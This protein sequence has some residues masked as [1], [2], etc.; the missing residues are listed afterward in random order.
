MITFKRSTLYLNNVFPGSG[1]DINNEDDAKT[2]VDRLVTE[3]VSVIS[4][5]LQGGGEGVR[6]RSHRT[7]RESTCSPQT[8]YTLRSASDKRMGAN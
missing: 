7:S 6:R 5:S 3:G 8:T 4:V 1:L 2:V